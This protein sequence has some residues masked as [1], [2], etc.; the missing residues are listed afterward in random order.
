MSDTYVCHSCGTPGM[1]VFYEIDQMPVHSV[2]LLP[3]HDEAVNYPKGTIKLGFCHACGFISNVVFDPSV[4]EYASRY[5]ETQGYSPTFNAFSSRLAAHLTER[6]HLRGKDIIEI[7]CGK[8][9]FLTLL[10]EM[11]SNHG[12]GFDPA[13]VR[14]RS[15]VKAHENVVFVPDFYSEKYAHH[16]ADFVYCKMTLE[17]IYHTNAFL[18]TV[19]RATAGH[20]ETILFFLLPDVTR[21]L[22]DMAFWDIYYEH[23]SYFSPGSLAR[24]FRRNGFTVLDLAREYNDQYLRIEACPGN[25]SSA[26]PLPLE[27][28]LNWLVE[29]V[30]SF[31]ANYRQK[32]AG[33][34]SFLKQ[35]H[36]DGKR[37]VLWG[38]GSK[39]VAFLTT[40]G[41]RDEIAYAVDI[42]PHKN[43][44]YLAGTGQQSVAPAFLQA[45]QPHTV[46]VMNGV[47]KQEI[48]QDLGRMGVHADVICVDS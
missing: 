3:T 11:G 8:G 48:Q 44:M 18:C 33:W 5:E 1:S 20:P 4:H 19:S 26:P 27:D 36:Q 21:I 37:V 47:Y 31:A 39:A 42:N 7:G 43:G 15:R 6:Y 46:I 45:Y 13:Y 14:E 38:A 24:L 23:C 17:H 2:L 10:C 35:Q 34:Q 25:G 29:G 28:D 12:L 32:L 40:L 9:E 30:R 16:R 41:I 22:R